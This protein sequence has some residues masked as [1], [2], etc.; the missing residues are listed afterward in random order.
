MLPV[1]SKSADV[2]WRARRAQHKVDIVTQGL[3]TIGDCSYGH[4]E[5]LDSGGA[6]GAV[7]I[8]RYCSIAIVKILVGGNHH[9]EWVS[10]Y[11]IR[12]RFDLP[13]KYTDGQPYTKGD[14][15]IGS[16]VWI[17]EDAFILS[18]VKI[19]SGAVI[20]ARSVCTRDV[21][22]YA[23]VGGNP[24]RV[25]RMRFD[26]GQIAALLRIAWWN[27]EVAQVIANVESLCSPDIDSFIQRFDPLGS[28]G[29][30]G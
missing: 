14:V 10:M 13:G 11:P 25:I 9:A 5:I 29:K 19:G 2:L 28:F 24:A 26:D 30:E 12:I 16:D 3:I 8:G 22:E 6:K 7:V 27:W 20:A 17:G 21:P 18:G 15:I 4:P 23:I 1:L